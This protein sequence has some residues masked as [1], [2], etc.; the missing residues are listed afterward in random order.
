VTNN[1]LGIIGVFLGTGVLLL[2]RH[3]LLIVGRRVRKFMLTRRIQAVNSRLRLVGSGDE[4]EH[5][6]AQAI[7]FKAVV[8]LRRLFNRQRKCQQG[9]SLFPYRDRRQLQLRRRNK[10]V[11]RDFHP[12][13]RHLLCRGVLVCALLRARLSRGKLKGSEEGSYECRVSG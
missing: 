3:L 13:G 7:R 8:G 5:E 12:T 4:E 10:D 9:E 1:M 6:E 11:R 2:L